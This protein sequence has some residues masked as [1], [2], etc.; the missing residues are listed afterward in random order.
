MNRVLLIIGL[1]LGAVGVNAQN[2][3]APECINKYGADS[4]ETQKNLS[5]FNQYFQEKKYVEAFPYWYYLFVNAPCVQKRV[6]FNGPYIIKKVLREEQYQP[7]FKG[8]VD[9]LILVHYKRIELWGDEGYVLGKLADD[10]AKLSPSQRDEALGIFHKSLEI[11]GN[12]TRYDVPKDYVY[13]AVKQYTKKQLSMDSLVM[14]LDEVSPIVDYNISKYTAPGRSK[15]DSLTGLKWLDT[16]DD[17]IKMLKPHLSCETIVELRGPDFNEN[18]E[19]L[20]WL[21]STVKLLERGGCEDSELYFN[22]SESLYKLDPSADA[23]LALGKAFKKSKQYSKSLDYLGKAAEVAQGQEAYEIY[24]LM[25]ETAKSADRFSSVRTYAKSALAIN[26]NSGVAYEL[27]GDAYYASA[28]SCGSG[29]LG[30]SGVYL[31][32]YDKYAKAKSV[33]PSLA[34]DLQRKLSI[35]ASR[36]PDRETAFFKGVNDGDSYTVGCWINETTVVRTTGG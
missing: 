6:T 34:D 19:N 36:F 16:Q 22:A 29:D 2:N 25:A 13:A 14:I 32:A 10:M 27:I 11:T 35:C 20:P 7:R 9:T 18:K 21:V 33:D 28:S 8:L 4:V 17:L 15:K 23:A 26:P 30:T 1:L 3:N 5:M 24:I 31:V 12:D